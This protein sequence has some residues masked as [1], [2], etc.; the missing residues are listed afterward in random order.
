MIG[1]RFKRNFVKD[2][3]QKFIIV[4]LVHYTLVYI[5][6]YTCYN[7]IKDIGRKS[8]NYEVAQWKYDDWRNLLCLVGP[9]I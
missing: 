4:L 9:F 7:E 2:I 5:L 1:L 6:K 8:E 3:K